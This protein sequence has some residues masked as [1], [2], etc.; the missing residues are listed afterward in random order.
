M[1]QK[2]FSAKIASGIKAE[3]ALNSRSI[4]DKI[5]SDPVVSRRYKVG[6]RQKKTPAM[7]GV[8]LDLN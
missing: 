1:N 3:A 2:L 4:V 6:F 5:R 8:F 7:A